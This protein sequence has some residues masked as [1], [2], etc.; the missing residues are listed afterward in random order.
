[1]IMDCSIV[2]PTIGRASLTQL[3]TALTRPAREQVPVFLVDDRPLPTTPLAAPP[4]LPV[5][6]LHSGG[7]GPSGARNVGW[8]AA[9]TRWVCFVDD[10]VVPEAEWLDA[11]SGDLAT[12]ESVGAV[13]SQGCIE[14][15][16]S[17]SASGFTDDER[18][19]CRLGAAL[20][21]T[22]DMA[23]RRDALCEVG[24][25]DER[26]PRAY[27]EDSD[28]ALRVRARGH[29][30]VRGTRFSKH[31][32]PQPHWLSS[33]KTQ[34][35]NRDNALMRR[36]F[37]RG[38]RTEIGE[39]PG[40]IPQYGIITALGALSVAALAARRR[41]SSGRAAAAWLML[42]L[43]FFWQRY[44]PGPHN[45]SEAL[46]VF[47]TSVLI[48]PAALVHRLIGEWT[49]RKAS[50][51]PPLAVLFDRD[52]T[53]IHDGP[54]L[55]DPR[56]VYPMPGVLEAIGKL[57]ASGLL[58]GVVTNQSGVARGLISTAQ[59]AAVN[60]EV[61]RQLGPFDAWQVCTHG[62][63]G[64]C[65]CRKPEPGMVVAAAR[66]LG[67]PPE[68]CVVIGDT[69]GDVHAALS[70][71]ARAILVPTSRTMPTE[72]AQANGDAAVAPSVSEA[73]SMVLRWCR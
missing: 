57:R 46:R 72:I 26:F 35:G 54:F 40:R 49:H 19:Q 17:D 65:R 24:G 3:M 34:I 64:G 68:R 38:W 48:P 18:R 66:S 6:V 14:V 30:I 43:D 1:M 51:D 15:V 69:G 16:T 33:V 29:R 47:A 70:A 62:V 23:Y 21:I 12:A 27:R 2:I 31:M 44:H 4:G 42:T 71:K 73:V 28:L 61:D 39:V 8:R 37:G 7:R 32:S 25:F 67:V 50:A 63:D 55:N 36:K 58:L 10:D 5:T 11:L 56:G 41:T 45:L 59:L 9:A 22:A 53:L 20:W 60:A 13:G 52:D